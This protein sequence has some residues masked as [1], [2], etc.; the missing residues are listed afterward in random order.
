MTEGMIQLEYR[1]QYI[2][3]DINGVVLYEVVVSKLY[4]IM[5]YVQVKNV[6]Q[7]KESMFK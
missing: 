5:F 2:G 1:G 7:R 3:V 6:S 4:L